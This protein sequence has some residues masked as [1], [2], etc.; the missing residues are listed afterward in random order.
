NVPAGLTLNGDGTVTIDANTPAGSYDVEY[1]ICEVTNPMNCSQVTSTVVVTAPV[2]EAVVDTVAGVDGLA[3]GTTGALTGNDTLNGVPVNIGTGPGDVVLTPDNVPAGLTLNGDGTVTIDANTPAGSYDVEYTICEVTNPM[4]CS[5]VTSTVVVAAP[6]IEAVAETTP[7]IDG[8]AGGTTAALTGND[9]LNGVPVNIGTG[10]GDV[11]LTPDN[12]PAGLTLNGDGTVTIDANTPAGSYDVE[13]TICEVTNPMNCSQITST[14]VVAAPVIEAVADTVAGV[15]GLAGGTTAALTGNDTLNGVPVNI[16]TGPG[17]VVLT[18]DNV[19]AGLTLNGDGTVTI[20]ANTPAGSYDVEYT[21]CE[22]TN[23]MNCS[24]ITS[25]VVV[26]APVI[27]AVADTVA[28]V[29]GLAGGTTGALTGNDTLNGVPVNI[30]T[31]PGDVVLTPDNVPAGLTLNGDGT[32]TIDANTPAGSYDV[33]Y[34]ICEVTNPMNC[35]QVTSTVVVAAPVIEAVADTVAGVDGLAGGTTAALTGNDTLN[36][37]PVN[38]GTGP[39]DV[40]LTPDNVP[41][42]LTL[43]GDG[44]V[45][46]DANTPAG[47]YDVEY[48]I[49]EVTNPMNCSQIT[50]M[51]VVTAPVIEAVADTVAGVDGLAGGTTEALTGNDTLNGVPVNI[52]TGPGDVALTPDNVPAGLTLNG[53]GTVT[54]DA[55]TPA[56]SYDVEYT[57]CEVTNPMN[58]SQITSM[59]VVTAPVIEAVADT[60]AGVDGLAGGTTAALT[61]NDTLNGVPVNIGTGP[62]DVVL[63]PDNVP[64]GLTLNG[65]GTVTIDANTPAGSYDVEYTICEVT[66]PMNCSQVTSTVVVAAPVIEAVVDIVAGVDGLAGGTTAALTGNDTLNGVP[67]NIGTGPGDVVLT[68]DNVPAGLTLNADGTVTVAPGTPAGSYDVEYT[69]CEVTNP[70]NCS[71]IT[72]TVVVTAPVIEAVTETTP[73]IDGLAG[74]TTPALTGNDT[75]NG[76]PVNIG[77]G[78]G[79]VV[80]TPDNVPAGLTLNGDGTVTIDANT[81]AGSYDVEYTICEVT[82]PMNCSQVTSTVVVTAP[83]IEAVVDI[84]AGVDGLAGGTTPALTGNDTLNGVPVNIGTG[85]GDV[86]LTPDNV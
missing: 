14:V 81:P 68:P 26:T 7:G 41:A 74:G 4:N 62:G 17:D 5:Q 3:G 69:I 63:T 47:S 21:I 67:V 48:T 59:V 84:V 71:Q 11:V 40:A 85:P 76:V 12:V 16:G 54:I 1:T 30:G 13:Y 2:I 28:G 20:D 33:E 86:V 78:P 70:M 9:T 73:G 34:T 23:P 35:S 44:T 79:D 39:G 15:D 60:V 19:P 55:N 49:C 51:V 25:T 82:N 37:V 72:S 29:D 42:G 46:I 27:E 18:P 43:N 32:V 66:N 58:C 6:V 65:D 31:G 53:D 56:G 57:I 52:G 83:V 80:L 50:S 77:T 10:P 45:T 24:Q 64:A 38:I 36:G 61:G 22:V 75:L 8:L